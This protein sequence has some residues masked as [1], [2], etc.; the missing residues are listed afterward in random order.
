MKPEWL[1]GTNAKRISDT[2]GISPLINSLKTPEYDFS[3]V[4]RIPSCF[5][6]KKDLCTS[7]EETSQMHIFAL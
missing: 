6:R 4:Q 1:I 5:H 2:L 3:S 7:V